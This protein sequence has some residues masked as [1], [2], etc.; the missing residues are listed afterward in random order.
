MSTRRCVKGKIP[1]QEIQNIFAV[2]NNHHLTL[3]PDDV[4]K[5]LPTTQKVSC[6]IIE[7]MK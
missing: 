2:Q 5:S 3:I 4:W 6:E 1:C 7:K